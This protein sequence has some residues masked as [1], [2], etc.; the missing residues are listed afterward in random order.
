MGAE[1]GLHLL[2]HHC[3][4]LIFTYG[5]LKKGFPNH[6]LLQNLIQSGDAHP[7]GVYCTADKY[8]LVCGPYKVPFLI[9]L[10]G[11]GHHIWGELYAVSSHA[12]TH[13]DELEGTE[14]GHYERIPITVR[15]RGE[16]KEVEA[17]YAHRNYGEELWK[18]SGET[19]ISCYTHEEANG[20]IKR[21][22]RPANTCFLDQ[23]R[24]FLDSSLNNE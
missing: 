16:E 12:L 7:L 3:P 2:H 19:G 11:Q 13:M 10:P 22:D 15:R 17:Y 4:T 9:N 5:T 21:S 20:Y 8:P 1:E 6:P 24:L 18:R 14:R 23:I